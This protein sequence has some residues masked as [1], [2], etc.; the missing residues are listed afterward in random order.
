MNTTLKYLAIP[1]STLFLISCGGGSSNNNSNNDDVVI[2]PPPPQNTSFNLNI[3]DAPVDDAEAVVITIESVT[4]K[5]EDTDDVVFE[6]FNNEAEGIIDADTVTIDLLQYQGND[7]FTILEGKEIPPGTYEQTIIEVLDE[8]LELSYVTEIG[9][10]NKSIK[11]PSD[12]LKLGGVTFSEG[13]ENQAFTVEF[14][15]R[16]SMTYKPGPDEYNLKPSGVR[17]VETSNTGVLSGTVDIDVINQ[18]L[19]C[20]NDSHIVYLYEGHSLSENLLVDSFDNEENDAPENAIVPFD[21]VAP[22]FDNDT[23]SYRY[24]IGFIPTGNYT[25]AYACNTGEEGDDPEDYDEIMIPNP[26][27]Q[28]SEIS[29]TSTE[30]TIHDFPIL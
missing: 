3:S 27:G 12:N 15:L 26:S 18:D 9:G 10:E 14:S 7:Q 28:I 24:E 25:V 21:A 11:V 30:T 4:F 1:L 13:E 19:N 22:A 16:K 2:E 29:I 6:T 17:I 5:R 20:L 8:D 23:N